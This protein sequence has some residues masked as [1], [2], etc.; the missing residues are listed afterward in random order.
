[1]EGVGGH[2]VEEE[3]LVEEVEGLVMK[4]VEGLVEEEGMGG[5]KEDV[6]RLVG[7]E[8]GGP[9][10]DEVIV[11]GLIVAEECPEVVT[12]LLE[13]MSGSPSITVCCRISQHFGRVPGCVLSS[14]TLQPHHP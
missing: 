5:H 14:P 12:G 6:E 11:G 4:E 9:A 8:V 7:E 1:M 2:V 3:G 10:E 13:A